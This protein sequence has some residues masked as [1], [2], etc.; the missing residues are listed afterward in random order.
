LSDRCMAF[1]R[2]RRLDRTI[3]DQV[4]VAPPEIWMP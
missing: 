4:D 3:S 2:L 1:F